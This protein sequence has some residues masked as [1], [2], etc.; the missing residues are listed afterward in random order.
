MKRI[1]A[2]LACTLLTLLFSGCEAPQVKPKPGAYTTPK[3]G[4]QQAERYLQQAEEL[5][6]PERDAKL[7]AA[8]EIYAE[9]GRRAQ[10]GEILAQ[11]NPD[12]LPA[13]E[14][15]R[16]SLLYGEIAL[17]NEDYRRAK[18][19]LSHPRLAA[20]IASQPVPKRLAW[21][22]LNAT[23]SQL[24]GDE[25]NSL[26]EYTRVVPLLSD[27][28]EIRKVHDHI[29]Q[30]LSQI[31]DSEIDSN[32]SAATDPTVRG[33]Y[34]LAQV[35]RKS[36]GDI[37]LQVEK[38]R[39]WQSNHADHPGAL[40]LPY[41]LQQAIGIDKKLPRQIALLL[42][43]NAEYRL[44]S[45]TVRDGVLAA[46]YEI[47][48]NGGSVPAIRFY[49][50]DKQDIIALY[51]QAIA[52]GAELVIGPLRKEKLAALMAAP[53]LPVPVLGLNY[54]E[55]SANHHDNLYQF[56]LSIEDE[57]IQVAERAWIAGHR[58]VLAITPRTGW[59]DQ[60]LAAFR[61]AWIRKGG[62][63]AAAINYGT[64]EEDYTPLL[65]PAFLVRHSRERAQKLKQ[66]LGKNIAYTPTRRSD[67]DMI[68]LIANPQN[69]RQIKPTLDFLYASDLPVYATSHI[70][71]GTANA[72]LNR[73][74]DG[75]SFTAM[76]W[77]VK[78]FA[79]GAIR[80]RS[81]LP[82]SY[83]NLFAMGVD[84]YRLHQWLELLKA[85]PDGSIHGYTGNLSLNE[86]N[87]IVRKQPWA[88]FD[89]GIAVP[90]PA[91]A[92]DATAAR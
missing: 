60:A 13:P 76:P 59:G 65:E 10:A 3:S 78:A 52:D 38:I 70:Y 42:P 77:T 25:S 49:D 8:G 43:E 17:Q 37:A 48:G 67:L 82:G 92:G 53:G 54:A 88:R 51:Q 91:L 36:Q 20:A 18:A 81:N 62:T 57:A 1:G 56:G 40:I 41:S 66:V 24:M 5:E 58:S 23:L 6:S 55:D 4:I 90:A 26:H 19:L 85:L 35:V 21:H 87:E 50:S 79:S 69:G 28:G 31:S 29:W 45:E 44:A 80:P 63:L 47:L 12:A 22:R 39:A 89:N 73:D 86:R 30:L 75:I 84:A 2:A 71:D 16:F 27:E 32:A 7:L 34:R 74:L 72:G 15:A 9:S 11:I 83:R 68:F 33:W 61:E 14:L 64:R 46:Y